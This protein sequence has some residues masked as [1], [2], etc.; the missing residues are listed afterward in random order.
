MNKKE[1]SFLS[2]TFIF[3]GLS[4]QDIGRL[5][6]R[7]LCET[8]FF[9]KGEHLD[10]SVASGKKIAFILSGECAVIKDGLVMNILKK[11]DSFGILSVFSNE[12]YPTDVIAKKE[13]RILFLEHDDLIMLIEHSPKIAMNVITFLAGR[14]TFLNSIIATLSGITVEDKCIAY[15]KEE[16]KKH[17]ESIPFPISGVARRIRAGRASL[18]RAIAALEKKGILEYRDNSVKILNPDRIVNNF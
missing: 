14:V 6:D 11:G 13:T 4:E 16:Y 3:K 18:Y 12:P 10:L 8:P 9:S 1:F 5:P 7:I 17:G 2:D 15:L